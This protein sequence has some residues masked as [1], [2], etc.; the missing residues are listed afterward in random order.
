MSTID[1]GHYQPKIPHVRAGTAD[2]YASSALPPFVT[3]AEKVCGAGRTV[4][5]S[6]LSVP[7]GNHRFRPR[8]A[9]LRFPALEYSEPLQHAM[10]RLALS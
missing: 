9:L 10:S 5:N 6:S 4:Q 1:G 2:G 7:G 3:L 8:S